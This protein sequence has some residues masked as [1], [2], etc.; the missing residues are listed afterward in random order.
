M[1]F[2]PAFCSPFTILLIFALSTVG[3]SIG[4]LDGIWCILHAYR[5]S[6]HDHPHDSGTY[7]QTVSPLASSSVKEARTSSGSVHIFDMQGNLWLLMLFI[8]VQ[9]FVLDTRGGVAIH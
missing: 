7:Y 4:L 6:C 2:F 8:C 3:R 1:F 9:L 5:P